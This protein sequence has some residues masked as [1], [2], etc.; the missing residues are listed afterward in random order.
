MEDSLTKVKESEYKFVTRKDSPLELNLALCTGIIL[1]APK[2]DITLLA[3]IPPVLSLSA[4]DLSQRGIFFGSQ[5]LSQ[6]LQIYSQLTD[7]EKQEV[8]V[9]S[10]S[11]LNNT[12]LM[13]TKFFILNNNR[14]DLMGADLAM[15]KRVLFH[16]MERE[17]RMYCFPGRDHIKTFRLGQNYDLE[18]KVN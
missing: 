11:H 5:P 7:S 9:L 6:V 15:P 14:Y 3:H 8:Y 18:L 17:I 16:P 13:L 12:D 4:S 2:K 10:G 1:S